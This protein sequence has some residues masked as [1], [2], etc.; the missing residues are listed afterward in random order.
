MEKGIV[1]K[2][3]T[4]VIKALRKKGEKIFQMVRKNILVQHKRGLQAQVAAEFVRTASLFTSDISILKEGKIVSGKS[5]MGVMCLAIR[6]GEEITLIAD[7]IDE[8][9]A[10]WVLEEFLS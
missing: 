8:Q 6:K 2:D 1:N 7:G 4:K 10:I 3:K 9:K 5:I